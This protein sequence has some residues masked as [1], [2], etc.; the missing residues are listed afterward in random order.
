MPQWRPRRLAAFCELSCLVNTSSFVRAIGPHGLLSWPEVVTYGVSPSPLPVT[1]GP[2]DRTIT[3]RAVQMADECWHSMS[4]AECS[5]GQFPAG[6]GQRCTAS[7]NGQTRYRRARDR[8]VTRRMV[9]GELLDLYV[10]R[11]RREIAP[12][13]CEPGPCTTT[14]SPRLSRE[15]PCRGR[16]PRC[17]DSGRC[18]ASRSMAGDVDADEFSPGQLG[19]VLRDDVEPA[20]EA[21]RPLPGCPT[22]A[23]DRGDGNPTPEGLGSVRA[24]AEGSRRGRS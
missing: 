9:A 1:A 18:F 22:V 20:D 16:W 2:A 3:R 7:I 12:L 4:D 17:D 15:R 6:R 10:D 19:W 13:P 21:E 14:A 23:A 5:L 11:L 8:T 24:G